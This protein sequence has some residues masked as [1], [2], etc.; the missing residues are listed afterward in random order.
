VAKEGLEADTS[1]EKNLSLLEGLTE[2][3][4]VEEVM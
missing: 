3:T 4:V 2:A 1:E